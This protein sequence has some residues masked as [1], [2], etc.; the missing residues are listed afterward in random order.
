MLWLICPL[1]LRY[2]GHKTY[3]RFSYNILY[4]LETPISAE[5]PYLPKVDMVNT[6][7]DPGV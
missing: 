6:G 4:Q 5:G 7:Y 2:Q 1:D 3:Y